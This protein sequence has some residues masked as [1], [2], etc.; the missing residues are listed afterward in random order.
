MAAR[1]NFSTKCENSLTQRWFA[2]EQLQ[3]QTLKMIGPNTVL[4]HIWKPRKQW[5]VPS[6]AVSIKFDDKK[7]ESEHY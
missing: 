5:N 3:L 1:I 2:L 7:A 4:Q 6:S